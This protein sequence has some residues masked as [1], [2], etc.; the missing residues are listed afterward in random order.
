MSFTD[1]AKD[2]MLNSQFVQ[3]GVYV[4][5][6]NANGEVT[7]S[8]YKRIKI[9]FA[10]SEKGQIV[11]LQDIFF[12]IAK[13]SWGVVNAVGLFDSLT[14]GELLGKMEPEYKKL[15]DTGTQFFIPKGMA[16]ARLI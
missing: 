10:R 3:K 7:A 9:N 12:D 15:I 11:N 6:F 5:L 14:G 16:I 2:D 13:S 8:E 1:K 4:G